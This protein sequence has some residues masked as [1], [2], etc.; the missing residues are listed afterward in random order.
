MGEHKGDAT[1]KGAFIAAL[2]K[3]RLEE[4]RVGS[5][6]A[7]SSWHQQCLSG[8]SVSYWDTEADNFFVEG[9]MKGPFSKLI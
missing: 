5:G 7:I 6:P 3:S 4:W 2:R 8:I 9:G 1:N